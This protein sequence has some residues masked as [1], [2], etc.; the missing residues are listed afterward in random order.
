MAG[1]LPTTVLVVYVTLVVGLVLSC[2][3]NSC[4]SKVFVSRVDIAGGLNPKLSCIAVW[5]SVMGCMSINSVCVCS[6]HSVSEVGT[7]PIVP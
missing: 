2:R 6:L 4:G 5:F 7:S 1:M 3:D